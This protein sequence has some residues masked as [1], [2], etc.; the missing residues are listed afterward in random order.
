MSGLSSSRSLSK[1]GDPIVLPLI[2]A[3][4]MNNDVRVKFFKIPFEIWRPL[5]KPR[6][7]DYC[8]GVTALQIIDYPLRFGFVAARYDQFSIPLSDNS[9]AYSTAKMSGSTDDNDSLQVGLPQF[10]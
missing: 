8:G 10:I 6:S 5:I 2:G 7:T 3:G 9:A 4:S 1:S